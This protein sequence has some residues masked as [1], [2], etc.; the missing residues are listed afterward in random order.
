MIR[1][2]AGILKEAVPPALNPTVANAETASYTASVKPMGDVALMKMPPKT[3]GASTIKAIIMAFWVCSSG[4][5]RLKAQTVLF[6]L[7]LAQMVSTSTRNV[8]V[9]MPP[10]VEPEEPPMDISTQEKALPLSVSF[11]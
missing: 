9:L 8:T 4:I 3:A 2:C 11:A 1:I 10:A 7:A 5:V 6:P